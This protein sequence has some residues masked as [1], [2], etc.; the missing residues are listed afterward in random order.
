MSLENATPADVVI[1]GGGIIGLSIAHAL[2][3]KD[4]SRV[5][6][7]ERGNCGEG[8]TAKATGGIRVQFGTEIN[9]RLSLLSLESFRNWTELIGGDVGYRPTGYVFLATDDAQFERL[10]RG[11]ALQRSLG[12]SVEIL[13][14]DEIRRRLPAVQAADLVGASLGPED[15]SADPGAAVVSLL[16]SCRRLGVRVVEH[17]EVIGFELAGG[18]VAG[19]VSKAGRFPA[20]VVVNAAG[21]WSDPLAQMV[22]ATL[23]VS[24]HHRQVYVAGQVAGL[25]VPSPL[26]IDLSTGCYFHQD[27]HGL[28]FGGGDRESEPGY[29]DRTW[30]QEA[31]RIVEMLIQRLPA[32]RDAPL[33]R[34]WAGLREM[35]PDDVGIVGFIP[36]V[37]NF[38]VAAGFSGHG[39]MHS[40]GV[41]EIA[42]A[43]ITGG[44]PPFDVSAMDPG[45]F[46]GESR[47]EGY[48]F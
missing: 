23:P 9:I 33:R 47:S 15:G 22:G 12:A 5:L 6:V 26:V 25:P 32:I 27:H 13:S 11:A 46:R 37:P 4:V 29:D 24:P 3:R 40:P 30:P 31:P 38:F 28:V 18:R 41:G 1:V 20:D 44:S 21:A 34:M 14:V 2:R 36:A 45:R 42:A 17:C 43:L 10:E 48:V 35:T 16:A 8:S 7:L 19:V 39:F